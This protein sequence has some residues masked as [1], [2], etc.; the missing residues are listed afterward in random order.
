MEMKVFN[1]KINISFCCHH[2]YNAVMTKNI[3]M[4][5]NI[6][7]STIVKEGVCN[8][9]INDGGRRINYCPFCGTALEM[10]NP[11]KGE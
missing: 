6:S 4:P 5:Q 7:A 8:P 2:M 1:D 11:N 9:W 3:C 10:P